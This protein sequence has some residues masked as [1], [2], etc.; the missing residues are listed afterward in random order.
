MP[1]PN[2]NMHLRAD[3]WPAPAWYDDVHGSP[4]RPTIPWRDLSSCVC[5][6][7]RMVSGAL[8]QLHDDILR[9]GRLRGN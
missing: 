6:S 4:Q 5:S 3:V 8:T 2:T 9:P 7:F 1:A